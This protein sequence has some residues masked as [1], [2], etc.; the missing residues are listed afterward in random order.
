MTCL[1]IGYSGVETDTKVI[2]YESVAPQH[3]Q[4]IMDMNIAKPK[5]PRP[6]QFKWWKV[7][8]HTEDL[9]VALISLGAN[10]DQPTEKMWTE[11]AVERIHEIGRTHLA[12]QNR[13][14]NTLTNKWKEEIQEAIKV[15]KL[16]FKTWWHL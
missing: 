12:R 9:T 11:A 6:K 1:I 7:K 15:K 16:A 3:R 8:E 2:L 5:L 4:I 14:E 13:E 10:T